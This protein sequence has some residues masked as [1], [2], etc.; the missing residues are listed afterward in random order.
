MPNCPNR[1]HFIRTG[2][3]AAAGLA[4]TPLLSCKTS[5]AA[6]LSWRP[7]SPLP[8]QLQEVY[9]AVLA[10]RI[11]VAG[12]FLV[13][14]GKVRIS[15][16]HIVYDPTVNS[17][18]ELAALPEARHH[19]QLVA[20]RDQLYGFAGFEMRTSGN[21]W[22]MHQQT[23]AYDPIADEWST[24]TA[25]PKKHAET[26]AGNL[27]GRIHIVG[28]RTSG[29]TSNGTYGDHQDTNQ[30]L[31][32]DPGS[33]SWTSA[34]PALTARNSAAGAVIDDQLYVVGGRTVADGNLANLEV[35]DPRE[36]KWR[37]AAP[38]PQG[39][40]G[41]AAAAVKGKLYAFGGEYFDDGGGV[42][43]QTWQYEPK[44]DRWSAITLMLTPRHGLAGTAIGDSIYAMAG[45][46][47]A[48]LA[49]TS[50]VL[51]TLSL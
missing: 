22:I 19:L 2:S 13:K 39:Q 30:H 24:K 35:Y 37:S 33:D 50:N 18:K 41:L 9:C 16:H 21:M 1:R 20:Y 44:K 7:K 15:T 28:G 43:P 49:E 46:K 48:S 14:D 42:Y 36:D 8:Y 51:E 31:V 6:P 40:G 34:A 29:G 23:W 25:A 45:A 27:S 26:V 3:L 17:W 5:Q 11:H 38:M 32:Y 10:K 47:R 4:L 12:G